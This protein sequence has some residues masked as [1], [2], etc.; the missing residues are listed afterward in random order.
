MHGLYRKNQL[1]APEE[2]LCTNAF[3]RKNLLRRYEIKPKYF[4][5]PTYVKNNTNECFERVSKNSWYDTSSFRKKKGAF[6]FSRELRN[7]NWGRN[8]D[9]VEISV[10]DKPH[11]EVEPSINGALSILTNSEG[12][13]NLDECNSFSKNVVSSNPNDNALNDK[14]SNDKEKKK[15]K[16]VHSPNDGVTSSGNLLTLQARKKKIH[17]LAKMGSAKKADNVKN[18]KWTPESCKPLEHIPAQRYTQKGGATHSPSGQVYRRKQTSVDHWK[19][20]KEERLKGCVLHEQVNESILSSR[21][22]VEKGIMCV[23]KLPTLPLDDKMK[24]DKNGKGQ[25]ANISKRMKEKNSHRREN[26]AG[27]LQMIPSRGGTKKESLVSSYFTSEVASVSFIASGG[28]THRG[29]KMEEKNTQIGEEQIRGGFHPTGNSKS[30]ARAIDLRKATYTGYQQ[31][32]RRFFGAQ[33]MLLNERNQEKE[34]V[35]VANLEDRVSGM[36]TWNCVFESPHHVEGSPTNKTRITNSV[37]RKNGEHTKDT[38]SSKYSSEKRPTAECMMIEDIHINRPKQEERIIG[39]STNLP[40]HSKNLHLLEDCRNEKMFFNSLVTTKMYFRIDFKIYKPIL[41]RTI[42]QVRVYSN[43]KLLQCVYIKEY[44]QNFSVVVQSATR[45][46]NGKVLDKMK[47]KLIN[48][49]E[50]GVLNFT[51]LKNEKV[52]GCSHISIKHLVCS[53][54]EGGIFIPVHDHMDCRKEKNPKEAFVQDPLLPFERQEINVLKS[55]IF[56]NYRIDCPKSMHDFISSGEMVTTRAKISFLEDMVRQMYS[57]IEDSALL[58]F[59]KGTRVAHGGSECGT[60]HGGVGSPQVPS[61][62]YHALK[63]VGKV[64]NGDQD[65]DGEKHLESENTCDRSSYM[66]NADSRQWEKGSLSSVLN[67]G[68]A[69]EG[70][71]R[72]TKD[73]RPIGNATQNGERENVVDRKDENVVEEKSKSTDLEEEP[74]DNTPC[75]NHRGHSPCDGIVTEELREEVPNRNNVVADVL[76]LKSEDPDRYNCQDRDNTHVES[77]PP[78]KAQSDNG[79]NDESNQKGTKD[80]VGQCGENKCVPRGMPTYTKGSK[81]N[82]PFEHKKRKEQI[83]QLESIIA[84][85]KKELGEKMEEIQKLKHSNNNT[86]ILYKACYRKL[87]EI[88]NERKRTDAMNFLLR[89]DDS[90]ANKLTNRLDTKKSLPRRKAYT[91]T[92]LNIVMGPDMRRINSLQT[93]L[94]ALNV[95][96]NNMGGN[97]IRR[98]GTVTATGSSAYATII[99]S[100]PPLGKEKMNKKKHTIRNESVNKTVMNLF[101]GDLG[102]NLLVQKNATRRGTM[103][104]ENDHDDHQF[105]LSNYQIKEK[106]IDA[107]VKEN[108]SLKERINTLT[109]TDAECSSRIPP[110]RD[111]YSTT[112]KK[113]KCRGQKHAKLRGVG[114]N[115]TNSNYVEHSWGEK[116]KNYNYDGVRNKYSSNSRFN[117]PLNL[118]RSYSNDSISHRDVGIYSSGC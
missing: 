23:H 44:P 16:T 93:A 45:M 74:W 2:H 21:L 64:E 53:G 111:I 35:K 52:I 85:Y 20:K 54:V 92:D 4:N 114:Q 89:F 59:A 22:S 25:L 97:S 81:T 46:Y 108:E 101:D 71:G 32:G 67:G 65:A 82:F 63:E 106:K 76:K 29:S 6:L 61:L 3:W 14:T 42:T 62:E 55:K 58:R 43:E 27:V 83:E 41:M 51:Y 75:S 13:K 48:I 100:L 30:M 70:G 5:V 50:R 96:D 110:L 19:F 86:N 1:S 103:T 28:Y 113:D 98:S 87:Q 104:G 78:G 57:F 91:E 117:F 47:N 18:E 84:E 80:E 118:I 77:T 7:I 17:K 12:A 11:D 115:R 8:Q 38:C 69:T 79:E 95:E 94:V 37:E 34:K 31:K 90:C 36:P 68:D 56:V 39:M 26:L 66:G 60:G 40:P 107:L 9:G 33:K 102:E 112:R 99:R 72:E 73:H 10:S 49:K 116:K 24:S 105:L 15:K 88:E 109:L